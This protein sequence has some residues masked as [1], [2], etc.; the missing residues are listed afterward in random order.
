MFC[1][2]LQ[3]IIL[4]IAMNVFNLRKVIADVLLGY[5]YPTDPSAVDL[6]VYKKI[7]AILGIIFS[8]LGDKLP[9]FIDHCIKLD[10]RYSI[11]EY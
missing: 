1:R 8:S 6:K 5:Q 10:E 7:L 9:Q 2:A 3:F 4:H 11:Y